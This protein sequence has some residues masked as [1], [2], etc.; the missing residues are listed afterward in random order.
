MLK[1][2][3]KQALKDDSL[4]EEAHKLGLEL[5]EV[6]LSLRFYLEEYDKALEIINLIEKRPS[7][8]D[9]FADAATKQNDNQFV[10]TLYKLDKT[11]FLFMKA[12]VLY[13]LGEKEKSQE[14]VKEL[15]EIK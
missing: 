12:K 15:I 3:L 10:K 7:H 5:T 9:A 11:T 14:V 6:E 1:N 8:D 2:V 13:M 4:V